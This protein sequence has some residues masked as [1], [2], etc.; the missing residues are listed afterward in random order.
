[1]DTK[2]FWDLI[3]VLDGVVSE[4]GA[5]RLGARLEALAPAALEEFSEHLCAVLGELVKLPLEGAEVGEHG[6]PYDAEPLPLVGDS[7]RYFL[8]AVVAGGEEVVE[9][10]RRDPAWVTRR[11]WDFAEAEDVI[12]TITD[13]FWDQGIQWNRIDPT[14]GPVD[15]SDDDPWWYETTHGTA[16]GLLPADYFDTILEIMEAI[17]KSPEWK[18]WWANSGLE[19]YEA[20]TFIGAPEERVKI[21]KGRKAIVIDFAFTFSHLRGKSSEEL[22]RVAF[23]ETELVMKT[24]TDRLKLPPHPPI[25]EV[26]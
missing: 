5:V 1:M 23:A 22:R 15:P 17:N 12:D 19:R 7:Y 3:G 26:G 11:D 4:E 8:Y 6:D 14:L 9:N 13:A 21:R 24:V 25:P 10:V 2:S 20:D 18:S 16:G